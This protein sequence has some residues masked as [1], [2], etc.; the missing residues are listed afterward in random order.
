MERREGTFVAYPVPL[1]VYFSTFPR[2]ITSE[3]SFRMLLLHRDALQLQLVVEGRG[4][5]RLH[6]PDF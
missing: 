4:R 6:R 1:G 2:E 5:P 3:V